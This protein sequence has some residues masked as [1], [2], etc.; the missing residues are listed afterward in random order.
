ML[1]H[2]RL[3]DARALL[4]DHEAPQPL[5]DRDRQGRSRQLR[6]AVQH[7]SLASVQTFDRHVARQPHAA[8]G[9]AA[10][11]DNVGV[12]DPCTSQIEID[13]ADALLE[14]SA[15]RTR[16]AEAGDDQR[17]LVYVN[18]QGV[19]GRRERLDEADLDPA[20]RRMCNELFRTN[21]LLFDFAVNRSLRLVEN[22]KV[23]RFST[24]VFQTDWLFA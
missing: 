22:G 9:D 5:R 11:H 2:Q 1:R 13:G 19:H 6:R 15:A 16:V 21:P 3:L 10:F 12:A 18:R 24:R 17:A 8:P 20:D 7:K 4:H 23:Y 14:S